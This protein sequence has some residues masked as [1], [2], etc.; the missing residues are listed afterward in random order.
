MEKGN[1]HS[2]LRHG[3][4]HQG[5]F[6]NNSSLAQFLKTIQADNITLLCSLHYYVS[7]LKTIYFSLLLWDLDVNALSSPSNLLHNKLIKSSSYVHS[8]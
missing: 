5:C 3:K 2:L 1:E 4:R 6:K 7:L 8:R